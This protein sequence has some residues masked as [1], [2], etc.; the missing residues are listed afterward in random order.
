MAAPAPV[1]AILSRSLDEARTVTT[2]NVIPTGTICRR[3]HLPKAI[4]DRSTL[5]LN[6]QQLSRTTSRRWPSSLSHVSS[7][8]LHYGF[9]A[10]TE[11]HTEGTEVLNGCTEPQC[12][13]RGVIPINSLLRANEPAATGNIVS[14][15]VSALSSFQRRSQPVLARVHNL[16]HCGRGTSSTASANRFA[17]LKSSS[18]TPECLGNRA[19]SVQEGRYDK[20]V[21]VRYRSLKRRMWYLRTRC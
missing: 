1:Y 5:Q 11:E 4:P 20:V 16:N 13:P 7:T 15:I 12:G 9:I 14:A 2:A 3:L 18:G 19:P 21:D 10:E 6:H 17:S 8:Q